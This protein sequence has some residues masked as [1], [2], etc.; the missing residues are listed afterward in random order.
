MVGAVLFIVGCLA[1]PGFYLLDV[2]SILAPVLGLQTLS[3]VPWGLTCSQLKTTELDGGHVGLTRQVYL[4]SL[5]ISDHIAGRKR[6]I[7]GNMKKKILI[8]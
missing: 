6:Q 5:R 7:E 4:G 1:A 2:R 3:S 8:K